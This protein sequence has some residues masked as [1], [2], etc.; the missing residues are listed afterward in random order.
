MA[1]KDSEKTK[2]EILL[3]AEKELTETQP[4]PTGFL[5]DIVRSIENLEKSSKPEDKKDE[6]TPVRMSFELD[7][8][9]E[10]AGGGN[11]WQTKDNA[12][13]N[14][15]IRKIT[16]PGGDDLVCHIIQARSNHASLFGKPRDNR[17]DIGFD[18]L[19]KDN[20]KLP[21]DEKEMAEL[22][23]EVERVKEFLWNTGKGRIRGEQ[24]Q[25]SLSQYLKMITADG[26]RYGTH[27]TEF[28]YKSKNGDPGPATPENFYGFRAADSGTIYKLKSYAQQD[29]SFRK[30][31]ITEINNL[32]KKKVISK[33]DIPKY[34]RGDYIYAQV[35]SGNVKQ[36]LSPDEMVLHSMYPNTS[37]ELKGYPLTPLDQVIH[38]VT[39]HYDITMHNKM[40]FQYGRA[41]RG[42]LVIKSR[43]V[44][45]KKLSQI[46]SQ[47]QQ[48]VNSVRHSHR[49]PVFGVDPEDDISW[50]PIDNSSRDMEFQYLYDNNI[51]VI[52]AA[53]GMSPDELPGYGHLSRG[54]NS[55]ALS[56]SNNE[57]K[58]LA[59][60]DTGIRPLINDLQEHVNKN[61]LPRIS[62]RVAKYFGF[63]FCGLDRDDP[64]K[65]STRL[66]QDMQTHASINDILDRCE[67]DRLPI[68]VGGEIP[69]NPLYWQSI[70]PFVPVGV[71][72]EKF[73]NMKNYSKD[74]RFQY[75]RDPFYF[76]AKQLEQMDVQSRL[77]LMMMGMQQGVGGQPQGGQEEGGQPLQQSEKDL[78]T[79]NTEL[80][81]LKKKWGA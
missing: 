42:M 9:R 28:L 1:K 66:Q 49:M 33:D 59:A 80:M 11:I 41:A 6:R 47:F 58:L 56:E 39:M 69:L 14:E 75:I 77:Q 29:D 3:S 12:L 22:M 73:F 7:P 62:E 35:I 64:Q 18:L 13:P 57:F 67:K 51:R 27:A 70:A 8:L 17:F 5:S 36:L 48:T 34:L 79:A 68:E 4:A 43:S 24:E 76:Q 78:I 20:S 74:P 26:L 71:I 61:I 54:T 65:E 32:S 46:R 23:D 25:P 38:A 63:A 50:Q 45:E 55:Q 16:G 44:D 53:F 81:D 52:L 15:L 40:Y 31:A 21:E 10:Y 30:A 19:P 72:M 37:W 60:R 2:Q